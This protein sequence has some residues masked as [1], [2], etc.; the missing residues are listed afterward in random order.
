MAN[1]L[2]DDSDNTPFPPPSSPQLKPQVSSETTARAVAH[3][4]ERLRSL[5]LLEVARRHA[6]DRPA[7]YNSVE[8]RK[9]MTEE[10]KTRSHGKIV[11]HQWQLDIAEC[12]LLGVDCELIAPTGA[13]KT[14]PFALPLFYRPNK[15]II[16]ISPLNALER[17][18]QRQFEDL[19][20]RAK[21]INQ[22]TWNENVKTMCIGGGLRSLLDEP[23]LSKR[24]AAFIVDEA[25][26]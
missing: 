14:I 9:K 13:G 2:S 4:R 6:A 5:L 17:D 26:S 1:H 24:L 3:K 10:C 11:P 8:A 21:A 25:L 7:K 15:T 19:G 16:V 23:K 22:E 12:L 20:L 18:Q